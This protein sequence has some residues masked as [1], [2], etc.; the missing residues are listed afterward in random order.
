VLTPGGPLDVYDLHAVASFTAANEDENRYYRAADLYECA[1]FT[2]Q[3]REHPAL[4][5]GDFNTSPAQREYAI[6]PVLARMRDAYREVHAGASV[7]G[8]L[9]ARQGSVL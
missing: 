5:C 2:W 1:R 6:V 7:G 4:C 8:R 9:A 3:S